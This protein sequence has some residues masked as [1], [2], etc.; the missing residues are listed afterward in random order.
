MKI[1]SATLHPFG[2][3]GDKSWDFE[4]HLT[5]IAEPNEHG[6]ST[7]SQAI[8]H[9]LFTP[10]NL[11]KQPFEQ[12]MRRWV[13]RPE[14]DHAAVTLTFERDGT[15]W[16]LKKRWGAD[17]SSRLKSGDT[18]LTDPDKVQEKLAEILGHNEATYRHILFTGQAELEDTLATIQ[19]N[20]EELGDIRDFLHSIAHGGKDVPEYR[21]R[22]KLQ[23]RIQRAFS[24][25]DDQ[26][27]RPEPAANGQ[28]RGIDNPWQRDAGRIVKCWYDW[29]RLIRKQELLEQLEAQESIVAESKAFHGQYGHFRAAVTQRLGLEAQQA[30]QQAQLQPLLKASVDW[31]MTEAH[32]ETWASQKADLEDRRTELR[33]EQG[34]AEKYERSR[35]TREDFARIEARHAE[36]ETAK[37]VASTQKVPKEAQLKQIEALH[38]AIALTENKLKAQQLRWQL[39][40]ESSTEADIQQGIDQIQ[41]HTIGPQGITGQAE[42]RV[43]VCAGGIT[44]TV[45]SG[46]EDVSMLINQLESDRQ[47]L[48]AILIECGAESRE[49]IQARVLE[50]NRVI[51]A[52]EK[53]Q[54]TFDGALGDK[55][56]AAWKDEIALIE[57]LPQCRDLAVI[58]ENLET[59][60]SQLSEGNAKAKQHQNDIDTWTKT[61]GSREQ[62]QQTYLDLANSLKSI[63]DQLAGFEPLPEAFESPQAML[64]ELGQSDRRR[65]E[66]NEALGHLRMQLEA[67]TQQL[68]YADMMNPDEA[69]RAFE[70]VRAEGQAY[71]YIQ[72]QLDQITADPASSPMA[73]F[74]NNVVQLFSDITQTEA[75]LAFDG[76][77]PIAVTRGGTQLPP[78]LLSRGGNGALALAIRLAMAKVYLDN[79]GGFLMFDDPLVN[80]D[81]TRM[82]LA[83]GLIK[84][85]A[86][87]TQILYF[88]CHDHHARA[89]QTGKI[90]H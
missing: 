89:L 84:G 90:E 54:A 25:W 8:Y 87:N 77:L 82:A 72:Q 55:P 83:T 64:D 3:F 49:E 44:L 39:V 15:T 1:C 21:L 43:Q 42:G 4:N 76:S 19:A 67:M 86:E 37:A 26:R 12:K 40:S 36:L 30:R 73:S 2:R 29:Q 63:E 47:Q 74:S 58:Q 16:T 38:A 53:S 13:P 85:Y 69:K 70:Q 27:C 62:L 78:E 60:Q 41:T 28:E 20:T 10:T 5:V 24:R 7:L 51:Q 75:D 17:A 46:E 23:D 56:L 6:K 79:G 31:P 33:I 71:L 81:A 59:V 11:T 48:R 52:V 22:E 50:A 9:A 65:Q 68:G 35:K 88:T 14:G 32:L 61:H 57:N 66:A 45:E 34:H 80:F 18:A